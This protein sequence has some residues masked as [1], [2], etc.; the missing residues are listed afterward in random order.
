[1][2]SAGMSEDKKRNEIETNLSYNMFV[3]AGAGAGKTTLIVRRIV[4]MLKSG[5]EPSEIVAITFTNKAAEELRSR[6]QK[7]AESAAAASDALTDKLYR[8]D[9]MNISTIHS[10]CSVLLKEQGTAA[11]LPQDLILIQDDEEREF[12]RKY[13]NDYLRTL[14]RND[15]QQ[16]EADKDKDWIESRRNIREYIEELYMSICDLPAEVRIVTPRDLKSETE[17]EQNVEQH[18]MGDTAAS[19]SGIA[20]II[21]CAASQCF[22]QEKNIGDKEETISDPDELLKA[23]GGKLASAKT[24]N[25]I[26]ETKKGTACDRNTVIK[27]LLSKKAF[28]NTTGLPVRYDK[29]LVDSANTALKDYVEEFLGPAKV[30]TEL[31]G[32]KTRDRLGNEISFTFYESLE[33]GIRKE[34]HF[35]TLLEYAKKACKYYLDNRPSNIITNDDLLRLTRDLIRDSKASRDHFRNK[36][37][38]F[39]VDEFQDTDSLQADFIYRLAQDPEDESRLRPGALFVVGDPKQSIYRFRGAEP[40]I[41]FQIKEQM[42]ALDNAKTYELSK[43]FRSNKDVI[44][45]VNKKFTESD[46]YY[47]IVNS[48][49]YSYKPMEAVN[50]TASADEGKILSGIYR[51]DNPDNEIKVGNDSY[52]YAACDTEKDVETLIRVITQLTS[53]DEEG[54]PR[55]HITRY[56]KENGEFVEYADG[57]KLSDFLLISPDT[58]KMDEYVSAL[59]RHAIPV[60]IDGRVSLKEDK[61]LNVYARIYRYLVNPRS[62]FYRIA[63]LEAIRESSGAVSEEELESYADGILDCLYEDCRHM[64]PYGKACYLERQTSVIFD[65]EMDISSIN[66]HTVRTYIRQ[67]LESIAVNI[68][69]TGEDIIKEMD[70]YI[71]A[72][73]EHELSLEETPEAVRF[74]NLHKAKGLE[75]NIVILLDR[76]GRNEKAPS[77]MR[78]GDKFYPGIVSR[79]G[80]GWSSLSG[81]E[82][83]EK[84]YKDDET[85]EFHRLEYVALTRAKQAAIFMDVISDGVKYQRRLFAQCKLDKGKKA[86]NTYSYEIKACERIFDNEEAE[87]PEIPKPQTVSY[88]AASD[89]Y[90]ETHEER[91][92]DPVSYIKINPS[93]LENKISKSKKKAVEEA[94]D[95]GKKREDE[96]SSTLPRPVGN[97][98]GD[99]LH[100]TME[101]VVNALMKDM[102]RDIEKLVSYCARRA[103]MNLEASLGEGELAEHDK[104]VNFIIAC[105]RS[106][107]GWLMEDTGEGSVLQNAVTAYTEFPFSYSVDNDGRKEWHN[108]SADLILKNK[109]G[110][111]TLIDYKSDNDYLV[112]EEVMH[113]SFEEKYAP[114][115]EEYRNVIMKLFG[116][117]S[118]KIKTGI[119]SFSQK[120]ENGKQLSGDKVRVRYTGI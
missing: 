63:A 30:W 9:E 101:L 25:I 74:M 48:G 64:T 77:F 8:L 83:L 10:F 3:E 4:N 55:F 34:R 75:G 97:L 86:N 43:N 24:V 1:M 102:T 60:V 67:M 94:E 19:V 98:I 78:T 52:M 12:K 73:L 106:Y 103:V 49:T 66:M 109:D 6:I 45:W 85:S 112:S 40:E 27:E 84:K 36:Y 29:D 96:Y 54:K 114:Q 59:K 111:F 108:G 71:E 22:D 53:K 79:Y 58:V 92:K 76:R 95:S 100:N 46:Q 87:M 62:P 117:S 44:D 113:R 99:A 72:G 23:A 82:D 37:R 38:T 65:K 56:K 68:N 69:G 39:F 116:V 61:A 47:H 88:M 89:D 118:D 115:L 81:I 110:S 20:D 57:I 91:M 32:T 21:V 33:N 120:D 50:K 70:R 35:R 17:I 7:E 51:Y 105:A 15:W 14:T 90:P 31:G 41:Y 107:I 104:Y 18:I 16:I 119:I 13:L 80:R 42:E 93:G 5:Y 2:N 26:N 28:L 11:G